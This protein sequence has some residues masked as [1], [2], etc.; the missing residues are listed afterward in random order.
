MIRESA[1]SL[2]EHCIERGNNSHQIPAKGGHY[3]DEMIIAS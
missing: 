2:I 3:V 1:L